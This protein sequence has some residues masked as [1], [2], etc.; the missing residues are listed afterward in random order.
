MAPVALLVIVTVAPGTTAPVGS[1]TVPVTDAVAACDHAGEAAIMQ[2]R[3]TN[4]MLHRDD[5][6][7]TL[8]GAALLRLAVLRSRSRQ[9]VVYTYK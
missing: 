1:V 9:S 4:A 2:K 8:L 7:L 3:P 5:F 6:I